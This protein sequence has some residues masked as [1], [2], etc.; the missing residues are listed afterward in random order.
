MYFTFYEVI[1]IINVMMTMNDD[2]EYNNDDDDD[3]QGLKLT[4]ANRRMSVNL[5][6]S[7][8]SVNFVRHF[9]R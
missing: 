6:V 1:S 3:N 7:G 2:D 4:L 5:S 9:G 8:K